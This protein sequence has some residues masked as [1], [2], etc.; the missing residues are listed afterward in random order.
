MRGCQWRSE[1]RSVQHVPTQM[2]QILRRGTEQEL[3]NGIKKDELFGFAVCDVSSSD[4]LIEELTLG[5]FLFPP[6][7]QRMK[8]DQSHTSPYMTERIIEEDDS[9]ER[10]TV[11]QTFNGTQVLLM[12]PLIKFYHELGMK[13]SNITSFTQFIGGKSLLPFADKVYSMRVEATYEKDDAKATTAKLYG[14]SGKCK[15]FLAI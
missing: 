5:G 13:I 12:T 8:L 3:L 11:V 7:I 15:T 2:G 9:F 10:S 14:N 4:E 1:I 6:V